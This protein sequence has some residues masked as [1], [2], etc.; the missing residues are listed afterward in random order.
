MS[1]LE[2]TLHSQC[3]TDQRGGCNSEISWILS[4]THHPGTESPQAVRD[5]MDS[6]A[7]TIGSRNLRHVYSGVYNCKLA[8]RTSSSRI[9]GTLFILPSLCPA[10]PSIYLPLGVP[11][12]GQTSWKETQRPSAEGTGDRSRELWATSC[13]ALV[14]LMVWPELLRKHFL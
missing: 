12:P 1:N 5:C 4:Y 11:S 10:P 3:R 13:E 9:P 2:S 6:A 14:P 7:A 8:V